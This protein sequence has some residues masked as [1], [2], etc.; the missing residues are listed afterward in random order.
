MMTRLAILAHVQ[1]FRLRG[2]VHE[3]EVTCGFLNV[4]IMLLSKADKVSDALLSNVSASPGSL[5]PR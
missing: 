4:A 2:D 5:T 3:K 1:A